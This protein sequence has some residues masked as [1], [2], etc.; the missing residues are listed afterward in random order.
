M[1]LIGEIL[2][3]AARTT[4]DATAATLDDAA[5]TF[6]ALDTESNRVANGLAGIG[7]GRGDRVLWWGDTSLE[8][9]PVFGALAK[10]GAVFAPLNAR[11]SVDEARP[12]AE[13]A[14]ARLL[15]STAGHRAPAAELA[16]ATGIPF[17][18][19]IPIGTSVRTTRPHPISRF[20]CSR[21][22]VNRGGSP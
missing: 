4:P 11:A 17:V 9:L 19:D 8:A 1:L 20:A 10:L 5:I 6:G 2:A 16:A 15:L 13:Y 7:I 22:A 18:A 14:R 3:H 12:V 21:T